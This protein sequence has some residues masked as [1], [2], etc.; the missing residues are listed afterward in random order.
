MPLHFKIVQPLRIYKLFTKELTIKT[1]KFWGKFH[2]YKTPHEQDLVKD[3][4]NKHSN[5]YLKWALKQLSIWSGKPFET[6]TIIFQIHGALDKTFP[7]N[8]I[9]GPN[10]ILKEAGHFMVYHL[11]LIHI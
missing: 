6:N 9:E 8:L 1:I 11:S 10:R 4:V 5:N 3:M 7:I 2:D